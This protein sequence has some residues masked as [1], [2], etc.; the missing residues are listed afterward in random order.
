MS[1]PRKVA[2][3]ADKQGWNDETVLD[4]AMDFM[5]GMEVY[6]NF[7]AFLERKAKEENAEEENAE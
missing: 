6:K 5:V 1:L 4:L 7:V 3:I 2:Q